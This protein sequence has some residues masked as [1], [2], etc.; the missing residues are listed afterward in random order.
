MRKLAVK[1]KFERAALA[2]WQ[3]RFAGCAIGGVMP[4]F[5]KR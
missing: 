5:R 3:P 2:E 4:P 1:Q